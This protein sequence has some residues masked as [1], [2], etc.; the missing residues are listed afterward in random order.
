MNKYRILLILGVGLMFA[1]QSLIAQQGTQQKY[2][3]VIEVKTAPL[4]AAWSLPNISAEFVINERIG[5][6]PILD[7]GGGVI[8]PNRKIGT[9]T[10]GKF[11]IDPKLGADRFYVGTYMKYRWTRNWLGLSRESESKFSL[12]FLVGYKHVAKSGLVF[13]IGYGLGQTLYSAVWGRNTN[14]PNAI[15]RST[16]GIWSVDSV[17]QIS[18]GYRFGTI[19]EPVEFE[20]GMLNRKPKQISNRKKR[21]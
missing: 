15:T 16:A 20:S 14:S 10:F 19:N 3:P 2:Q 18:V 6:E 21:G 8:F 9:R 5:I 13:D 4:K 11:Y 17:A 7:F 1:T 12:G